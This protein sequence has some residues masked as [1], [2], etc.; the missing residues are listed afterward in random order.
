[1]SDRLTDLTPEL[2][3]AERRLFFGARSEQERGDL[4]DMFEV[5]DCR[6]KE[7]IYGVLREWLQAAVPTIGAN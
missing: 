6:Q 5:A 3:E 1:M 2:S 4:A 7:I